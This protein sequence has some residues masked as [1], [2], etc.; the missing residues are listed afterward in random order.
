MVGKVYVPPVKIQGIK[1]KLVSLISEEV[2]ISDDTVWYEPFMGSGVVGL[3]LAPQRAVFADINPYVINLYQQIKLGNIDSYMVRG[4]LEREGKLLEKKDDRYYYEVRDRFNEYHNPLDFLFLNRS[5][6][7]GMIRFNKEYRFNVPYCHK[8]ARF[9]KS[10]ITKIVNQVKHL[11][12]I[13]KVNSWEF[14]CQSFEETISEAGENDFIYCDPPY[15]GR[16]VDYYDSWNEEQE[17]RLKDALFASKA[18]F[19]LSTWDE[20]KYRKNEYIESVWGMCYKV[21]QEHFYFIGA[22]EKNRNAMKEALLTNYDPDKSRNARSEEAEQIS[23]ES[24][25]RQG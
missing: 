5:C 4:Y 6:F 2:D 24:L 15:I 18:K 14:K 20:N 21:N 16:H 13:L 7:N 1:T 17:I 8:P 9:S 19:M 10:Y 22:S 3:N 25:I 23:L 11:E 12:E